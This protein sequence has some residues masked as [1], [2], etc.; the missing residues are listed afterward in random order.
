MV[1]G[2]VVDEDDVTTVPDVTSWITTAFDVAGAVMAAVG[3]VFGLWPV[4]GGF[5]LVASAG[6]VWLF[7]AFVMW[8]ATAHADRVTTRW[9]LAVAAWWRTR[10][11]RRRASAAAEATV[12]LPIVGS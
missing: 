11:E 10:P 7:S 9:A 4:I 8:R 2:P 3:L 5:A 1:R 12:V 6:F